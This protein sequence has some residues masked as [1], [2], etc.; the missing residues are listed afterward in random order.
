MTLILKVIRSPRM[1]GRVGINY[2]NV[3]GKE[4][5]T[6]AGVWLKSALKLIS[7]CLRIEPLLLKMVVN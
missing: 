4:L 2:L 1:K 3:Y 6:D 7:L 5:F